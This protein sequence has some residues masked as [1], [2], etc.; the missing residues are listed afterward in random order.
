M[1]QVLLTDAFFISIYFPLQHSISDTC[2]SYRHSSEIFQVGDGERDNKGGVTCGR[3]GWRHSLARSH[4]T[5]S[6]ISQFSLI[7]PH[8]H[9]SPLLITE[10]VA[11]FDFRQAASFLQRHLNVG[12]CIRLF[13]ILCSI[14][15]FSVTYISGGRP[16]FSFVHFYLFVLFFFKA[17][18][19]YL[20]SRHVC[21]G[22]SVIA[23]CSPKIW[24]SLL[25][26]I[27]LF[28]IVL[29]REVV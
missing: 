28:M 7:S 5:I 16:F 17:N 18:Y 6:S 19:R 25:Y 26:T 23:L 21:E 11:A 3:M 4:W 29:F 10:S 15:Y 2:T 12:S 1:Y 20:E 13:L 27:F 22:C 9:I 8:I 14:V 24:Q